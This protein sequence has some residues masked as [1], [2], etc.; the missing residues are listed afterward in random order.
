M[1]E[2]ESEGNSG[3]GG[4]G[5]GPHKED[6]STD[7]GGGGGGGGGSGVEDGAVTISGLPKGA[8]EW[9]MTVC[10]T[11]PFNEGFRSTAE[12]EMGCLVK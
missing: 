3:G 5:G 11:V 8:A 6:G 12:S 4:G 10:G 9:S 1:K 7:G 2:G